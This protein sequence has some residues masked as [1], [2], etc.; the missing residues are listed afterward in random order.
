M[1]LGRKEW[2]ACATPDI[3]VLPQQVPLLEQVW[4]FFDRGHCSMEEPLPPG[5]EEEGITAPGMEPEAA[6]GAEQAPGVE[7]AADGQGWATSQAPVSG[8]ADYG[9]QYANYGAQYTDPAY[10]Y[11]AYYNSYYYPQ[12]QGYG[13]Q[14]DAAS[15]EGSLH[16]A[17]YPLPLLIRVR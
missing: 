17:L 10:E 9:Y 15:G 6:P 2:Q 16:L 11:Q 5:A 14:P 4:R 7:A 12:G 13:A 8:A 3:F 1:G